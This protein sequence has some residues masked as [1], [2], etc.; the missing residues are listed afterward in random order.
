MGEVSES[1]VCHARRPMAYCSRMLWHRDFFMDSPAEREERYGKRDRVED[2]IAAIGRGEFVVVTDDER[3][4]NEGDLIGS[5]VQAT[6]ERINFMTLQ[7][8]GLICVAME[9]ERL[10]H[11]G[12]N[13]MPQSVKRDC[14]RTGWM[15]SVDASDGIT[16]GISTGD[17]CETIRRLADPESTPNNFIRPG[18]IFPLEASPG[19][20][21]ERA[22][23]TEAAVDLCLLADLQP[24]GV[25]CEILNENGT[26]ARNSDLHAFKQR[27]ELRLISI[28]DLVQYRQMHEVL[29]SLEQEISMP[30]KHGLFNCRMYKH[31]PDGK[32]HLLLEHGEPVPGK[33]P[34]VRVHSECLTGDVL[35]SLRCDCGH[36]LDRSLAAI[37]EEGHGILIYLRQEGRGIGLAHKLQAYALQDRGLD[38]VEANE[39]LGFAADLRDYSIAVQMLRD[40]GIETIRLLTNNPDKIRELEMYGI[41][42][43]QRIPVIVQ[44]TAH[45][46][47]YLDTKKRKLGHLL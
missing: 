39:E 16:S 35:G 32:H 29:V 8:R 15:E 24:C 2:A 22:G 27:N 31:L 10:A 3:R 5:A 1:V 38:T 46:Q 17:R 40:M 44:P 34:L 7:G 42:V 23:H 20:V 9:S 36:Q 37:A 26:M 18:H 47:H 41:R 4:E 12:I 43:E 25:I 33:S 14:Y 30:L 19:G 11:L 45:N 6:P 13:R 28:Q 21:L